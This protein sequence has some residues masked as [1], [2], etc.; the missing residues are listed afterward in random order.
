VLTQTSLGQAAKPDEPTDR[1]LPKEL[2][3][4]YPL[5][6]VHRW[7][8]RVKSFRLRAE[9]RYERG[10]E[11]M[12]K[13]RL[14]LKNQFPDLKN[15]DPNVFRELLPVLHGSLD[16]AFDQTR[17]RY[18]SITRNDKKRD[19]DRF[20]YLWDGKRALI[21]EHYIITGQNSYRLS[22]TPERIA[23]ALGSQTATYLARQPPGFCWNNTPQAKQAFEEQFGKPADYVLVGREAYHGVDCDVFLSSQGNQSN[24]YYVGVKDGRWYGAKEG[25]I[26]FPKADLESYQRTIEDFLGKKL[27]ENPSRADW[28]KISDTLRSLPPQKRVAWC[29][30]LYT[31]VARNHTPVFEYWFSDF[32]DVGNG[33]RFPFHEDF[34]FYGHEGQEKV[35]IATRL[36]VTVQDIAINQPLEDRLF[37]EPLTEGATICDD[38][39]QPPL[40][41]KHKAKFTPEEW[42]AIVKK[43][44]VRSDEEAAQRKKIEQL[45]GTSAPPLPTGEWL[46]SKPLTWADLRGKIVV[47][48]FWSVGCA[49]CYGELSALR[50]PGKEKALEKKDSQIPIV[51]I[52]VHTPGTGRDEIEK[53]AKK[54]ELGAPIC[55]DRAGADKTS[56]GEFFARCQVRAMPTSI[57]VDEEGRILAHGT[58]SEVISAAGQHRIKMAEKK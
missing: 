22:P 20:V 29:R 24:R 40:I 26:T 50:G 54:Y 57:A 23:S 30:L 33:R 16:H 36:T 52:G 8:P 14:E 18:V 11:E 49:P 37:Q 38:I 32:R 9:F 46:N 39:H 41:Y 48:K 5:G 45:I 17:V 44:T 42:A 35:Y 34:L 25:I 27:G 53:V 47:L 15:P 56:W 3:A 6:D 19:L 55:I 43:A 31:R 10:P 2:A 1:A 51:F 58:F 28:D 7:L 21:H 12:A 13:D 4:E